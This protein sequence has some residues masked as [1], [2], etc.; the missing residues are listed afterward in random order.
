MKLWTQQPLSVWHQVQRDGIYYPDQRHRSVLSNL[1][2]WQSLSTDPYQWMANQLEQRIKK[3]RN[4]TVP[5]WWWL[6]D[7]H[8]RPHLQADDRASQD[9][10]DVII[11]ADINYCDCLFSDFERWCYV[12]NGKYLHPIESETDKQWDRT[13]NWFES[14]SPAEQNAELNKSWE[15][16]FGIHPNSAMG[17]QACTWSID[18]DTVTHVAD[19]SGNYPE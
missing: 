17:T 11:E 2:L 6:N 5:V 7:Q 14:L 3:P 8:R 18:L 15:L 1:G 9:N 16:I 10:P 13:Q 4:A 19:A 12:L